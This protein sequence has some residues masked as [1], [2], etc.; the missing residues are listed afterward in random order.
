MKNVQ[1]RSSI[2][3]WMYPYGYS[4]SALD[5]V[6]G[7]QGRLIKREG[8]SYVYKPGHT[9][10][11][12]GSAA[13]P[14]VLQGVPVL[15]R[16]EAVRVATSKLATFDALS[17]AQVAHVDVTTSLEEARAWNARSKVLGRDLDH[18]SQG[19]GIVVYQPGELT[20]GHKFYT[21]YYKKERELR[22]HVFQG[23]VIFEQEKLKKNGADNADKY[24]RSHD[25]G[26]CFAFHH[27]TEKPIPLVVRELAI[28]SV[29]ALGLDF[30]AVDI[31]WNSKS[32][33]RVFEVNTA[34][35]IEE[36]SLNAYIGA[37]K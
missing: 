6:E 32:G 31:G 8:S 2:K 29:A 1:R 18:G 14:R 23:R 33:P 36:T 4:N 7:L 30:G 34:P 22:I 21:K 17:R 19:R 16:F 15:N 37:F 12:W 9:V 27:L 5:L 11:N 28:S 13:C 20:K 35:G 24:V 10:I 25:R 26:W 3:H